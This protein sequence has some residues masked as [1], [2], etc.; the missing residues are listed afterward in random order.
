[1][2]SDETPN[3]E[4]NSN[5]EATQQLPLVAIAITS[6]FELRHSFVIGYFVIRHCDVSSLVR[7]DASNDSGYAPP[8]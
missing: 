8:S 4:S 7:A 2:T 6:S 5:D 1:M 3:D